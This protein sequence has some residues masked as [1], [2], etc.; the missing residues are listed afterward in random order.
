MLSAERLST[1]VRINAAGCP[2]ESLLL[3]RRPW[4]PGYRARSGEQEL[5]LVVADLTMPAVVVPARFEGEITI[6]YRP[7]ALWLGLTLA[8]AALLLLI[9]V[10]TVGLVRRFIRNAQGDAALG[11]KASPRAIPPP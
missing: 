8:L 11:W 4:F 9:A 10:M 3:L 1:V 6:E 2:G 5:R 7:R